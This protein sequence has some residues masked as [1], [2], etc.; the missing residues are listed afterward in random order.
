MKRTASDMAF[1]EATREIQHPVGRRMG[2]DNQL[3]L[4]KV[5]PSL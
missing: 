1:S 5:L 3:F 4:A 2:N